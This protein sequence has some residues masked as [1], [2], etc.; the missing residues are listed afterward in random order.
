MTAIQFFTGKDIQNSHREP[1]SPKNFQQLMD[2]IKRNQQLKVETER[3]RKAAEIDKAAYDRLK[4]RLPYF[5][6][7]KFRENIRRGEHF[8]S[9][10]AFILDLDKL[11]DT[12]T[13][14]QLKNILKAD[15]RIA[16]MYVSPGG[17]GLKV[18]MVLSQECTS[19]KDYSDFYK[20]FAKIFAHQ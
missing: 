20:I 17:K 10:Q 18:V 15:K 14:L 5:C 11:K 2:E 4:T 1:L 12:E 13:V 7:A 6:C 9:I 3:I 8:V 16:L 19:L